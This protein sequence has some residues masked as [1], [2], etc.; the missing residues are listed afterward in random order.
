MLSEVQAHNIENDPAKLAGDLKL[1]LQYHT[2]L[3]TTPNCLSGSSVITGSPMQIKNT[4]TA[5][6]ALP[7]LLS[8][9]TSIAADGPWRLND[10]L[11]LKNGFSLSGSHR[12]RLEVVS[13]SVRSG[14]S[15]NDELLTFLTTLNAEYANEGLHV[16]VE[17]LDARQALADSD[18]IFGTDSLNALDLLQANVEYRFGAA[19]NSSVKIG[20]ITEDWGSRRLLARHRYGN[21]INAFDGIE[22]RQRGAAGNELRVLASQP[23]NKL[24]SDRVSLRDNKRERD[25]SSSAKKFYGVYLTLPE[26]VDYFSTDFFFYSLQEAD[27]KN[28]ATRNRHLNSYGFRLQKAPAAG[29]FFFEVESV[30]QTG[31]QRASTAITDTRDL[32]HQAY[33]NYLMFGY[34]FDVPSQLRILFE[35]DYASGDSDPLDGDSERFDSLF[36]VTSFEFGRTGIYGVFN[37]SNLRTPGIRITSN[38]SK[39]VDLMFAYRAFWLAEAKDSWGRTGRRDKTGNSGTYVGQH[40]EGRVRWNILPGSVRLEAGAVLLDA[41]NLADKNSLFSYA[42]ATFTF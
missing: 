12:T 34:S 23:V 32:D 36:G 8:L 28:N 39:A 35:Y 22:F 2:H 18:S 24:P 25:K 19:D 13:D 40:L 30:I 33:F 5:L 10:A 38:P 26:L 42:A 1:Q 17:L 4:L 37:R 9:N 3:K 41:K 20:R 21:T 14:T 6:L 16:N 15:I 29:K 31:H 27:S 11:G 7:L